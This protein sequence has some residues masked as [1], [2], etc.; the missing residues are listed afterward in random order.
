L[1]TSPKPRRAKDDRLTMRR[2]LRCR[3]PGFCEI[4]KFRAA[5]DALGDENFFERVEP[6][7]E[8]GRVACLGLRGDFRAERFCPFAPIKQAALVER[9]GERKNLRLPGFVE[10]RRVRRGQDR[11]PTRRSKL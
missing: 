3:A 10:R 6:G 5:R 11:V 7:V 1:L 4:G 9:D 2:R 8:I